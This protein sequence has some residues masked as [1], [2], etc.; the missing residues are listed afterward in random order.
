MLNS[1][2]TDLYSEFKAKVQ[3]QAIESKNERDARVSAQ[4]QNGY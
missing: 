3:P 2:Q 1:I 4:M